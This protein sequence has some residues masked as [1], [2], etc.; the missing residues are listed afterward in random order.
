MRQEARKLLSLIREM[1]AYIERL[2]HYR[3]WI[4][5]A[6]AHARRNALIQALEITVEADG[7]L[8]AWCAA[9]GVPLEEV[10]TRAAGTA[11][12]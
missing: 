10:T 2:P 1:A 12:S 7:G 11:Q 6:E 9:H 8:A 4:P 5:T 3:S